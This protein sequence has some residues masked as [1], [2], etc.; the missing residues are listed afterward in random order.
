MATDIDKLAQQASVPQQN[1]KQ[2]NA[3]SRKLLLGHL[4]LERAIVN[5]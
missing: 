5:N 4:I 1:R 2:S 3:G